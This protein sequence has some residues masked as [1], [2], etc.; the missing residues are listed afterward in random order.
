[1]KSNFIVCLVAV[2]TLGACTT[3]WS[4]TGKNGMPF[5]VAYPMCR[6]KAQ[7]SAAHQMPFGAAWQQG[8]ADFPPDS[9]HDI[10]QRE[11]SLCLMNNGFTRERKK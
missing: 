3:E 9:R 4:D 11:T 2:L 7:K 5:E 6:E 10:E 8:P 1:M